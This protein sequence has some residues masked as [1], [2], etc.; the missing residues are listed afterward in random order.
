MPLDDDG[1]TDEERDNLE[2]TADETVESTLFRSV[3]RGIGEDIEDMAKNIGE[4]TRKWTE[5][6][7][8]ILIR[9]LEEERE[10]Q[11]YPNDVRLSDVREIEEIA[12]KRQD[13]I[14][15]NLV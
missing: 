6:L 15:E 8:G 14:R 4:G 9:T 2:N 1:L 7:V 13:T 11:T 3:N 5:I 10:D 12:E